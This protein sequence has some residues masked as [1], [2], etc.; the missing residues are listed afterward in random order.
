MAN[1]FERL[2]FQGLGSI[3]PKLGL[4]S[5]LLKYTSTARNLLSGNLSGA[6]NSWMDNKFGRNNTFSEG[7]NIILAGQSWDTVIQMFEEASSVKRERANLWHVAVD[8]VGKVSAPRVNLLATEVSFNSVQLGYEPIKI[9]SGFTQAPT[10]A[11][12]TELRLVCYDVDGEIQTWMGRLAMLAAHPDGTFGVPSDY[13]NTI[14][15]T[16]GAV[17]EGKGYSKS[18][19]LL[20]VSCEVNLSRSTD[21][22]TALNLSFTQHDTFGG[23]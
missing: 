16:H 3:T 6:A 1:I 17:E 21:E 22:F 20:P 15:V 12:P 19:V 23:L 11:E 9:G 5:S 7:G 13:A 4:S 10:G 2:A 14:T 18:W 8:P